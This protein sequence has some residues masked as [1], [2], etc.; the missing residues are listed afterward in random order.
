MDKVS[1]AAAPLRVQTRAGVIGDIHTEVD[2][3]V[4]ALAVLAAQHVECVLATGDIADGPQSG[5]GVMKA[6][7]LLREA[8]AHVV[9]G[10][11]DRWMLDSTMRDFPNATYLDDID[12]DTRD[13]LRGLPASLD[14][15]TRNGLLLLGH[16]LGTDDMAT[17][18]PYDRGPE[19]THNAALQ[20]LLKSGRYRYVLGGHTHRRMVRA[21]EDV[22]FINAGAIQETREPCCLVL[23]FERDVAQFYDLVEGRTTTGPEWKL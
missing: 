16:G 10:N 5:E 22:T 15:E 3:L 21:I 14:V 17:L 7:Q 20:A 11:H 2:A 23:D 19:L 6:C 4:W 9:Q 8:G 18:Y 12:R 13:Y 1:S